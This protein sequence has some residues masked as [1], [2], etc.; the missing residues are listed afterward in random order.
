MKFLCVV[1]ARIG[2][3]RLKNKMLLDL[4]GDPLI[5]RVSKRLLSSKKITQTVFAIP[6]T[7][8]N[9]VLGKFLQAAGQCVV[10]GD[11]LNVYDRFLKTIKETEEKK[12]ENYDFI[13]RVCADNPFVD[14][15][16]IDQLIDYVLEN[17]CDYSFNNIPR[18]ENNYPDGFGAEIINKDVLKSLNDKNLTSENL[19]HVTSYIW[20]N[21]EEFLIKYPK[22]QIDYSKVKLD[23]DNIEDYN[24]IK[25]FIKFLKANNAELVPMNEICNLY[26]KYMNFNAMA[27]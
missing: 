23:I 9:E 19:E 5:I 12:S 3:T 14:G 17:N 22:L 7:S 26:L 24:K 11:E 15:R 27:F 8:E 13:I 4:D 10:F 2:S 18:W 1:Q 6:D 20:K 21:R 16:V 25:E